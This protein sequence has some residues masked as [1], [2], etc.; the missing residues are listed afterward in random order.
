MLSE[1]YYFTNDDMYMNTWKELNNKYSLNRDFFK[2][3]VLRE[4]ENSY[5]GRSINMWFSDKNGIDPNNYRVGNKITIYAEVISWRNN[6]WDGY[7]SVTII[8]KYIE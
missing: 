8:P 5:M 4:N 1:K 7:N 3:C 6:T 2:C